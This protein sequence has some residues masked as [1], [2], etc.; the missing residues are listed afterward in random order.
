ML[1]AAM[2]WLA[3]TR[4]CHAHAASAASAPAPA[5]DLAELGAPT[6]TTFTTRDGL[7]DPVAVTVRTDARGMAWA[8][9]PHG[10]AW[11]DGRRWQPLED[12]ALGGYIRQLFVDADGTLWACGS[13][14]GLARRDGARWHLEDAADGLPTRDVR[15]LV[16]TRDGDATRLWA[17]SPDA[18][19]FYRE[20]GRWHADP[21][22]AQLPRQGLLTLAQTHGLGGQPRLWAGSVV[23][24]LWYREGEGRWQRFA[25]PGFD[26]AHGLAYLLATG[27]GAGEALWIS[28]FNAGLWRLDARGLRHWSAAAGEL[29]SDIVYNLAPTPTPEGGETVWGASRNGLLR[30]YRDHVQVFDRRYGLPSDA[31]RGVSVWR[32]PNGSHVLWAATE[33]GI[34]RAVV[35]GGAWKAVSL[36]GAHQTGV[37]AV[38][39]DRDARGSERLWVGSDGDGLG[40][41]QDGRWRLTGRSGHDAVAADVS[42]VVRAEDAG[43]D[44]AVWIGSG[45]GQLARARDAG[46]IEA[47]AVPWPHTPGQRLNAMLSRRVDGS[48]EQWFAT[49]LSGI[50]RRRADRWTAY[51]APD[52]SPRWSVS[53]LLAQ[54]TRYGDH[55][56]WATTDRGLAR[57]DGRQWQL[58]GA[59]IG[60]PDTAL[61]GISLIPDGRG[62]PILWLGS[63]GHGALRVDV[64]DPAHPRRLPDDLPPPPD[65]TVDGALADSRGRLYLC[66]D[67]GVQVLTPTTAGYDARVAT[68]RDGL[69]NN[70]CNPN[71]QFIDA[72]DRFWTGTLGGLMVHDPAPQPPDHDPKTL[73]L[74]RVQLD[75][76]DVAGERVVIPPGPHE[77]RVGFALLSWQHE[78]ESRFRTWLEGFGEAPGPWTADNSREIGALPH[79]DYVL[80]IEARDYAGNPSTP[81]HL[82]IEVQPT[83][84]QRPWAKALY[85]LAALGLVYLLLRWRTHAMARRQ[86]LL[87]QRIDARTDALN[88]ANRQLLELSRHDGLTGVFNRRWLMECLQPDGLRRGRMLA[89]AL[90]FIDVDDFK[91]FN[92]RH[93]HIAGDRALRAVADALAHAAPADAVVARYG[94]EEFA[95]LWPLASLADAH[96][97]AERFRREVARRNVAG[98]GEPPSNVT[99]S[100][101]V[102]S[103][104]L[105]GDEDAEALLRAADDALY[106]AKR[107]GRNCVRDAPPRE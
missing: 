42:L 84:W 21:G 28:V 27:S 82:P 71:A 44:S 22:N 3:A 54:S 90:V 80:H 33:D 103:Y 5:L 67:S 52:G 1:A 64:S 10:L 98:D 45:L 83:A 60:L 76:R 43:G 47:V 94:G 48:V 35:N 69:L 62:R 53:Q 40:V 8:G 68:I 30:I 88:V 4:P 55:W 26:P 2:L 17:V 102:A 93:G 107:A 92:D 46:P 36:L 9:T 85:L 81:L 23:D 29:P 25:A 58:L 59:G 100:A 99:I 61:I 63:R 77:L 65:L 12:P 86:R 38:L 31:V 70:E 104:R 13:S 6:F 11:Y 79:G 39:V 72:H 37:L 57:F 97:L 74:T 18:G 50:Y 87:E 95:C 78:G 15:R 34:A 56:L 20:G 32:S 41:Y 75:G 96:A 14:F 89:M 106:A 49:D 7:P 16:Q 51:A 105:G 19:L 101:G 73:T 66:S 24:G 91:A